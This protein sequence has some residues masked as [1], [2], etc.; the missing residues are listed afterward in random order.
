LY[1]RQEQL[2]V[3]SF[4]QQFWWVANVNN[5]GGKDT[6]TI[7]QANEELADLSLLLFEY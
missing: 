2:H 1:S 6:R 4:F 7:V 5:R 3:A